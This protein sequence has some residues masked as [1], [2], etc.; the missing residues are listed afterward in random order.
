M[1]EQVRLDKWLWA[2]RFFKTRGLAQKAIDGGKVQYNGARSKTSKIVEIGALL[3][4]VQ[5]WDRVEVE[6]VSISDRRRSAPE[7]QALYQE[8]QASVERRAREAEIRRLD[9]SMRPP[10]GRPDKRERRN[11]QHFQRHMHGDRDG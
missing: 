9:K 4:V 1:S 10:S 6:I 8:T 11:I 5:G 7:A 2:A 3:T